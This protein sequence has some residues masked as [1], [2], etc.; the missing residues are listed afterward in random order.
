MPR[1]RR[2]L[3][4]L[5]MAGLALLVL[6]PTAAAAKYIVVLDVEGERTPRL[7]KAIA[8]MV[9]SQHKMMD[10]SA[11]L[12]ASKRLRAE[13]LTPNNVKKVCDY[14]EV[15]GV[16][17]GTL[18]KKDGRYKFTLRLRSGATG[19]ITKKIPMYINQPGLSDN[20]AGQLEQ[21]LLVAIDDLPR[22]GKSGKAKPREEMEDE[23]DDLGDEEDDKP[24]GM[25][26][27]ERRRQAR[28]RLKEK[29]AAERAA[30][31]RAARDRA[32]RDRAQRDAKSDRARKAQDRADRQRELREEKARARA[33]RKRKAKERRDRRDDR[34]EDE[35][36]EEEDVRDDEDLAEED[37]FEDEEDDKPRR[38]ASR[39]DRR[40]D[41]DDEQDP[42]A[43]ARVSVDSSQGGTTSIRTTPVLLLGGASF[44]GRNL[45]FSHAG[46][47]ADAPAGYQG[48][49]VPGGY[50]AG[51]VYPMAF[52]GKKGTA[53]NIGIGFV[54]DRAVGL[55][56]QVADG[57]GGATNLAT[58][59][60]RYGA[61]L[62]YRHNFG[63]GDNGVSLY[64][65]VGYTKL[66]FVLD[67]ASAPAAVVVDVPNVSYGYV[68]PGAGV[69]IPI[70][71]KLAALVEGRFLAVLSAGEI[72]TA[73]QYGAATITGVD[74]DGA[75]EY[76]IN[77]HFLA[78]AGARLVLLGYT[79]KGNGAL[80]DRNGDGNPDVGGAADRYLGGYLTAGYVF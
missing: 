3:L 54:A 44:I 69:R 22:S 19:A 48:K 14:L 52:G 65:Q 7:K 27:A 34:D 26:K 13:K 21:R 5:L 1:D 79:F 51:E 12:R 2:L 45:T 8:R 15:D 71:S 80:I 10:A 63:A 53:A 58:R 6:P 28:E 73:E 59:Q 49:P 40:E 67:K 78:R 11:Y 68:D 30:K 23:E 16:I 20:M 57:M 17:D 29:R 75:I 76:R 31:D 42:V 33:E 47:A 36:F 39:D 18:V 60:S 61:S 32:A 43:S 74:A 70:G 9:K 72:Q 37:D 24:R 25:T 64:A 77:E 41:E 55:K 66:S 38:S 62:R 35:D 4:F 50:V 46:D 56:S